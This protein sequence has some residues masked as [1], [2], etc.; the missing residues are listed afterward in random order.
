[1]RQGFIV[2]ALLAASLFI[3]SP[4][5]AAKTASKPA[6]GSPKI[7]VIDLNN[8]FKNSTHGQQFANELEQ[9]KQKLMPGAKDREDKMKAA[10]EA[11]DKADSKSADYDKLLKAWDDAQKDYQN[12]LTEANQ[13]L[14]QQNQNMVGE[15]QKVLAPVLEKYSKDNHFDLILIKGGG[16]AFASE[17]YDIST[18][19]AA[20]LDKQWDDVVKQQA[21]PAATTPAPA[22][23]TKK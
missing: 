12:Y 19:V 18:P 15:F 21:P 16:V 5:Q 2:A 13:E 10:K 17:A 8:I 3:L 20:A 6:A 7:G 11:L 1:M 14:S 22:A 9:S 4:A 23:A